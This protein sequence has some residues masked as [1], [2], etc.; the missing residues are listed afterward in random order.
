MCWGLTAEPGS[1]LDFQTRLYFAASANRGNLDFGT[2]GN[3][4]AL[5]FALL[6]LIVIVAFLAFALTMVVVLLGDKDAK[7]KAKKVFQ[8]FI[9]R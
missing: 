3:M 8:A 1:H 2:G 9:K 4:L 5:E 7:A 6:A